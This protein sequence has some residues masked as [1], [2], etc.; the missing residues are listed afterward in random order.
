MGVIAV[1]SYTEENIF[2]GEDLE[3][4]RIVAAQAAVA[5]ENAHLFTQEQRKTH[6]LTL[7][8]N[9][10]RKAISTLNP[11]DMLSEIAAEI[12]T[13]LP[14]DHLGIGILDY[15]NREVTIQAEAGH[16]AQGL[17]QRIKLGEGAI[18]QV[19]MSG[20]VHQR[21]EIASEAERERCHTI[22]ADARSLV[23]LPIIYA[24][25]M[26]GVLNVESRKP[27]AFAEE[28]VLL[29]RT[30]ADQLAGALHNAFVFQKAK[31]QAITDGLTG[32]KTHRFFM[33]ALNA[34]WRRATRVGR[35]F[36][37]ALLDL[38]KFKLVNDYYGH[39][40][41]D[42]VLQRTGR[43]L[44]QN[45]RRS[46]VVARYGGDE[47]V[48]LMPET[49]AEQAYTIVEKLRVWLANDPLLRERK[50]TASLGLAAFPSHASTPQELIQIADASMYLAKHQGGNAVVSA[51]QYR[52]GEQKEWQRHV[53]EAYLGVTIKRLFST[54]PEAFEEF[55]HRLEH[56]TESLGVDGTQTGEVPA[57]VLETV[58]SLAFAIDAKDHYTQGHSQNVARYSVA[59]GRH[60]GLPEKEVEELR[61]AA[62][63]HDVGKI[64]IPES[65]LHKPAPLE[66]EEFE[67]MKE[68]AV[69]G[70]RILEPLR[71]LP[72]IQAIVRHHHEWVDGKGYPEG[73][74]GE[75]IPL[76]SRIIAI[77]DAFD[78][79]VTERT[80][81][82]S[83]TRV[84]ALEELQRCASTQFDG[85]LVQGFVE[86]L[87]KD[88]T[89][90]EP[91]K[92]EPALEEGRPPAGD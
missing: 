80:Y 38:D 69:L 76:A 29:L 12:H 70:A 24:D 26:L 43:I 71:T 66:P 92:Y 4:L 36:S 75:E 28:D 44:E 46:D 53:L 25:Q 58:T 60:L 88:V 68:H 78:T 27:R 8:N 37:L 91:P 40:E 72:A 13:S 86:A 42:T 1:V 57:P 34:E 41:G 64:G 54:G 14:Y 35:H 55:Y 65:I 30:L 73:L 52:L 63:L 21:E 5:I 81:K 83:R 48:V 15:A 20:N 59:L 50:L 19:V 49:N 23:A 17:N 31:E 6:H 85:R 56:V 61:L 7:L 39:L 32:V 16:S 45:V 74:K 77:A 22:L 79:M 82:R 10:S 2:S 11:E 33:E 3:I 84:D 67:V 47:F 51:D 87:S 62:I 9:I 90:G 89:L 18:G